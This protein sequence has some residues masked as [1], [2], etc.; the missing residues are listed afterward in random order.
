MSSASLPDRQIIL[1]SDPQVLLW[2]TLGH[3][4][5]IRDTEDISSP[6]SFGWFVEEDFLDFY[7]T[8]PEANPLYLFRIKVDE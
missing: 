2:A 1:G 7:N 8:V 4:I 6:L 3:T 5:E